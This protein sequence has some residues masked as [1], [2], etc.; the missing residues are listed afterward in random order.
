MCHRGILCVAQMATVSMNAYLNFPL[1]LM[2]VV[3]GHAGTLLKGDR[4]K[5]G[6]GTAFNPLYGI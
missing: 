3:V 2:L 5:N 4:R 6:S 1:V